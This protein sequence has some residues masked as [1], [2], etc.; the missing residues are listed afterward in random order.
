MRAKTLVSIA[1]WSALGSVCLGP[2]SLRAQE[3][4]LATAVQDSGVSVPEP[5]QGPAGTEPEVLALSFHQ[6]AHDGGPQPVVYNRFS[7]A[8]HALAYLDWLCVEVDRELGPSW[9]VSLADLGVLDGDG[10]ELGSFQSASGLRHNLRAYVHTVEGVAHRRYCTRILPREDRE[11]A[12]RFVP[13][14]N[15]PRTYDRL[16]LTW[17]KDRRGCRSSEGQGKN[18]GSL[19]PALGSF[20]FG[21]P[22]MEYSHLS[23]GRWQS[24]ELTLSGATNDAARLRIAGMMP[25]LM[26][27]AFAP[28]GL[29]LSAEAGFMVPFTVGH[30][31]NTS[32]TVSADTLG[33]G[34]GTYWAQCLNLRG[35]ITP[36]LCVG[37]SLELVAEG[38]LNNPT[39]PFGPHVL[40]GW[41]VTLGAGAH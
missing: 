37:A 7:V 13:A 3:T 39:V 29:Q 41:F 36:K 19:R 5:A 22:A 30:H 11:D 16:E 4:T 15:V 33:I 23:L 21:H 9:T 35:P 34:L 14:P 8:G 24:T 27:T 32:L 20:T 12:V 26:I 6:D 28:V 40:A 38:A 31:A 2:R 25:L 1:L 18:C 10:R 17:R